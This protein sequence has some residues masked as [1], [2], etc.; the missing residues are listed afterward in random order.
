MY[1]DELAELRATV[2]R[3]LNDGATQR[4]QRELIDAVNAHAA[5]NLAEARLTPAILNRLLAPEPHEHRYATVAVLFQYVLAVE[6]GEAT[7]PPGR[8]LPPQP[9]L[10]MV[11]EATQLQSKFPGWAVLLRPAS[12]T[13]AA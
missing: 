4:T 1:P 5:S 10:P 12:D 9:P 2:R 3:F 6:A 11:A 8:A 7:L 13:A